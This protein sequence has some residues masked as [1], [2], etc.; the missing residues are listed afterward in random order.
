MV[1]RERERQR[2]LG[3]AVDLEHDDDV[4]LNRLQQRR[5]NDEVAMLERPEAEERNLTG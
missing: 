3:Y 4:E 1:D 2:P 5:I